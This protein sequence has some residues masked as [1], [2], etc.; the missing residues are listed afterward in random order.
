MVILEPGQSSREV[1][2]SQTFLAFNDLGSRGWELTTSSASAYSDH[3]GR[4]SETYWHWF[5]R[6]AG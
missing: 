3:L 1:E 5:R 2:V 4:G 6:E